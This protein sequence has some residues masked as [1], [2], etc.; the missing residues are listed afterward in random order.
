M[1]RQVARFASKAVRVSALPLGV[2]ARFAGNAAR[3]LGEMHEN[4]NGEIEGFAHLFNNTEPLNVLPNSKCTV[5]GNDMVVEYDGE[6]HRVVV[7]LTKEF[8]YREQSEE[9]YNAQNE[10]NNAEEGAE[11]EVAFHPMT[12]TLTPLSGADGLTISVVG[13]MHP[14]GRCLI[15]EITPVVEGES[16]AHRTISLADLD[17]GVASSIFDALDACG[18]HTT[19]IDAITKHARRLRIEEHLRSLK[20]LNQFALKST[21]D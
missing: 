13:E 4:L 2:P 1:F 8:D 5:T 17:E 14:D 10:G 7:N 6:L 21:T 12:A 20:A 15:S 19:A 18:L 9:E 16:E 3:S 11:E